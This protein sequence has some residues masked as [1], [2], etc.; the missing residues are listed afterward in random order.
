MLLAAALWQKWKE[1]RSQESRRAPPTS[2]PHFSSS[3]PPTH[4]P[5]SRK[6]SGSKFLSF[7]PLLL[8]TTPNFPKKKRLL[9]FFRSFSPRLERR[10][11]RGTL[12]FG[13]YSIVNFSF[14]LCKNGFNLAERKRGKRSKKLLSPA[15]SLSISGTKENVFSPLFLFFFSPSPTHD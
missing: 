13:L 3:H 5:T 9:P 4:R 2:S 10:G 1:R 8:S 14:F 15:F 11:K 7:P 6:K 12:M